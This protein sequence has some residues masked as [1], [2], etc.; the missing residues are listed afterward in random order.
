[1]GVW[2]MLIS[3]D[4]EIELYVFSHVFHSAFNSSC[5][6]QAGKQISLLKTMM[7]MDVSLGLLEPAKAREARSCAVLMD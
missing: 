3:D 7:S 2:T 6:K 5:K 1:M 4:K